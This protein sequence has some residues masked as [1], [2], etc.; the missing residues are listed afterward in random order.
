MSSICSKNGHCTRDNVLQR[1]C[2]VTAPN[3]PP[4][5]IRSHTNGETEANYLKR[6]AGVDDRRYLEVLQLLPY[7]QAD[8]FQGILDRGLISAETVDR[9]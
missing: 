7:D 8:S 6:L 5:I 4:S 3:H 9:L 2:S 1:S